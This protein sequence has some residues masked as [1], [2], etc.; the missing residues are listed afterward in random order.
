MSTPLVTALLVST[1]VCLLPSATVAGILL[2]L[3]ALWQRGFR[4][5]DVNVLLFS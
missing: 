2:H 5:F 1:V 3:A 4:H